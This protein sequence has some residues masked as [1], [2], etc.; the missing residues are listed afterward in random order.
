MLPMSFKERLLNLFVLLH[1]LRPSAMT[2]RSI[3]I[4]WLAELKLAFN[5][6]VSLYDW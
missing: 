6:I 2:P 5:V 3:Q 1:D 4:C